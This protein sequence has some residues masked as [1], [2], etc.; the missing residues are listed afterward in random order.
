MDY[1]QRHVDPLRKDVRDAWTA[2][3]LRL[4]PEV[5]EELVRILRRHAENGTRLTPEQMQALLHEVEE[6]RHDALEEFLHSKKH[7]H[8]PE[9]IGPESPVQSRPAQ[10]GGS[11]PPRG[12]NPRPKP[13][14]VAP[15]PSAAPAPV[16]RSETFLIVGSITMT[17]LLALGIGYLISRFYVPRSLHA[18]VP[19]EPRSS[20]ASAESMHAYNAANFE[21]RRVRERIARQL[22]LPSE[23]EP[24]VE[25]LLSTARAT[26]AIGDG[27]RS[28]SMYAS[29]METID[30]AKYANERLTRAAADADELLSELR[31]ARSAWSD[32]LAKEE[33]AGPS[34]AVRDCVAQ[35]ATFEDSWGEVPGVRLP[36]DFFSAGVAIPDQ[37][38]TLAA[39][40][41]QYFLRQSA[42]VARL[43]RCANELPNLGEAE[44]LSA[45]IAARPRASPAPARRAPPSRTHDRLRDA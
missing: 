6:L 30:D 4:P 29:A 11:S 19:Q 36:S 24:L 25:L 14:S 2:Q 39:A 13:P 31:N 9:E 5:L 18:P 28:L 16:E 23:T 40:I 33:Q 34:N 21:R 35:P 41:G 45:L 42:V 32:M 8:V 7:Q 1:E 43:A 37:R 12:P 38:A 44:D 10:V 26:T 17:L 3:L 22:R 20:M 27:V 15:P